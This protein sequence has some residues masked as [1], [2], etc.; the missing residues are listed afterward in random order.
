MSLATGTR[1]GPYEIL[2]SLGSGG[3]GEVYRARDTR[4]DR[5]VAIK[6]LPGHLN[7]EPEARLRFEREARAVSSLNH[8][9]IC[10][11]HDVGADF[12]VMEHLDGETLA[13]RIARGP[14]PTSELL[15]IGIEVADALTAAH[16]IGLVHRDLKPGNVMLTKSGAKLLDF[17]LARATNLDSPSDVTQSPTLSRPL[18]K[19]GTL[20]G[21]FQY[22][23]P[24]QLEGREA[25]PR[26]D[27][28]AFG[29]VL[30]EMA[31][32]QRAFTGASQASLI[33]SI[34]KE[35]PRAMTELAPMTPPALEHLVKRCLEK[36][37]DDRWQ[38][39][40]DIA[41][42]LAWIRD[43]G[44]GA[45]LPAP[46]AAHRRIAAR[47]AWITA[48][49]CAAAAIGLGTLLI[50]NRTA[51]LDVVRFTITSPANQ[52]IR[53]GQPYLAMAPDGNQVA[54]CATDTVGVPS[55][56][57]RRL[58]TLE[59]RRISGTQRANM[60][61][62]SHD[63]RHIGFFA[64]GKLQRVSIDGGVVQTLCDAPDA[65]GGTWGVNDDI[66]FQPVASG[67]LFR[68]AARGGEARAITVVDTAN[69]EQAHRF[70][71]FLPDGKHFLFVVLPEREGMFDLRVGSLDGDI[72][73]V[74]IRA[75]GA[76]VYAR[77]G[78]LLYNRDGQLVAQPFDANARTTKGDPI[79]LGELPGA[80]ADFSGAPGASVS[81]NGVLAHS[82]AAFPNTSL[83]WLERG[84]QPRGRIA[85]PDGF[86]MAPV[87]S[88][89]GR[90][91]CIEEWRQ[92][93]SANLWLVDVERN[94]ATRF[95]FNDAENFGA[96]WSPDGKSI[97]FTSN[98]EGRENLYIK[99]SDGSR[100]EQRLFDSGALFTKTEDW[101]PDGRAIL[102]SVLTAKTGSDLWLFPLA[103]GEKPRP[104]VQSRF[105]EGNA[106]LSLDGRLIAYRCD[107]SGRPEIYAQSF[108][109]MGPKH[110]ASNDA[111]GVFDSFQTFAL[112]WV[113]RGREL[114][115][116][117]ADGITLLSVDVS[118]EPATLDI[119]PPRPAWR[120]PLGS[121]SYGIHPDGQRV[122][123]S[124]PE[125]GGTPLG[126][127]VVMNWPRLLAR[128]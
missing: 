32:G 48:A 65:R 82:F 93:R 51:P 11:L 42:E 85:L 101:T 73:P 6:V 124:G 123:V 105:N 79:P 110:R 112:A 127:T 21:T 119:S 29:A 72:S 89:D 109:D 59:S 24:E 54:F 95:T 30:Y 66:V 49:V 69:G 43:A 63:S 26:T 83:Q 80:G 122:L 97:V 20:V 90:R 103:D 116:M 64:D 12:F 13:A 61:F 39:A 68:V 8:P 81:D 4:L 28:F 37:P 36:N 100:D 125:L 77:P 38:S 74:I 7:D 58:D 111:R 87:F 71:N 94:V 96:M 78:F 121:I 1:L 55:V 56:W 45:G 18:T 92:D 17:G 52:R 76:A 40:R 19:A 10:V 15:K 118:G 113:G 128:E 106:L 50:T 120:L 41:L 98:R 25:D 114:V 31:T 99:P 35:Q 57:V 22:M 14:L 108:P 126:I 46:V 91:L 115:Y 67:P 53:V 102:Y 86:F 47:T 23:A 70:P 84:G 3:M 88:R 5:T 33:A 16:R 117:A 104:L 44:S 62:W 60:L 27:I 34:L 107:D 9:N 75:G 2:G